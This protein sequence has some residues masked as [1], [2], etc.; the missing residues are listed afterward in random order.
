MTENRGI[1]EKVKWEISSLFRGI[2]KFLNVCY[3]LFIF[4]FSRDKLL[5]V[6]T[7]PKVGTTC[8]SC[9]NERY[10]QIMQRRQKKSRW[11]TGGEI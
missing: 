7:R 5:S 6:P 4:L 10:G 1:C 2:Y 11:A 3:I 8:A 9:S